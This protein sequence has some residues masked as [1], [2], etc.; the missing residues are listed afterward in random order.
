[1]TLSTK[2]RDKLRTPESL[3]LIKSEFV[4]N[5]F[6]LNLICKIKNE[7]NLIKFKI[8]PKKWNDFYLK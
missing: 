2:N 1:M 3:R 8:S 5:N 6:K 4:S 7:N